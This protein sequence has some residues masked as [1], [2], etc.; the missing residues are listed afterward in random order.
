M[1][2]EG[3]LP[4]AGGAAT[5]VAESAR[6]AGVCEAPFVTEVVPGPLPDPPWALR[7]SAACSAAVEHA[8]SESASSTSGRA[9][10]R[11]AGTG[12]WGVEGE[13]TG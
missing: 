1:G 9:E 7:A 6:V 5:P 12:R 10:R 13:R 11:R 4:S 8:E 3:L 2:S